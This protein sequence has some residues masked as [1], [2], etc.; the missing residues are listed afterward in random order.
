MELYQATLELRWAF[1]EVSLGNN[2][3]GLSKVL[4]QKHQSSNG[5]TKWVD[6]PEV[7]IKEEEA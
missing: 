3:A 5:S 4:Q 7:K 2:I 6:V 1:K